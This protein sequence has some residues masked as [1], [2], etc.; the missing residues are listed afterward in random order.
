MSNVFTDL[1][2]LVRR[3]NTPPS[4]VSRTGKNRVEPTPAPPVTAPELI[5]ALA[6][7]EA[8]RRAAED[9]GIEAA[10]RREKLLLSPDADEAIHQ[11]GR[12]LAN[13]ELLVER[14]DALEPHLRRQLQ[15]IQ[16]AKRAERW[17]QLRDEYVAAGERH[18]AYLRDFETSQ[19]AARDAARASLLLEFP[20]S[21]VQMEYGAPAPFVPDFL[22]LLPNVVDQF[23]ASLDHLRGKVFD[24][25]GRPTPPYVMLPAAIA[26]VLRTGAIPTNP[27]PELLRAMGVEVRVQFIAAIRDGQG[28]ARG[29]G[30]VAILTGELANDEIA[31][32]RARRLEG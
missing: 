25:A 12:D 16:N 19:R 3:P 9:A 20:A 18:L 22:L 24:P 29:A 10:G 14:L 15:D 21:V 11:A 23:A 28:I 26:E 32:G 2:T 6:S 5:A 1:L 13:A 7:L 8:E 17:L 31:G 30:E 4:P 27:G